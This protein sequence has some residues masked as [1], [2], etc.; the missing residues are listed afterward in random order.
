MGK[1]T[2][3]RQEF[4]IKNLRVKKYLIMSEKIF[5]PKNNNKLF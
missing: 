4:K 2:P 1:N 5:F 3:D